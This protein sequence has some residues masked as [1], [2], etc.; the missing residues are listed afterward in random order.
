MDPKQKTAR[1]AGILYLVMA[2]FSAFS[3]AY[4]DSK[5][6]VAEDAV[7]TLR[8]IQESEILFRL[9]IVSNLIGQVLFLFLVHELYKLLKVVDKDKA[10]LM[11]ILV[12][13][14]VPLTMLNQLHQFAPLLVV[15]DTERSA[16][17]P[18][19]LQ[20]MAM[21]F[22]DLHRMG[23]YIAE[24]FWGLW[25]FP[26]GMLVFKSG[27]FPKWLGILLLLGGMGY[28][29]ESFVQFLFPAYA[30]IG[31]STV[32]I[33]GIAE[34]SFIL[35]ILIKGVNIKALDSNSTINEIA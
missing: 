6:Y 30:V 23:I 22:Y 18:A 33:S 27:F 19:Q 10:R 17:D 21:V 31:Y 25:L 1:T 15:D 5:F 24:I 14:S 16:F 34:F 8:N 12:V 29:V 20:T 7:A 26:F 9:G 13:A 28:L 32:A 4:I 11:A 2:I 35:W 3:M